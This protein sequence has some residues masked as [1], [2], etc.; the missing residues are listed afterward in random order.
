M[1]QKQFYKTRAWRRCRDA[2]I[3]KRKALD[4]GL[5]EVCR[6]ELGFIVHHKV[7]LNDVNCN[8]PSISLNENNLRYECLTCHNKEKNPLRAPGRVQYGEDGSVTM[9]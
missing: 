4:G 6:D 2:Y 5:C 8:D 9:K 3:S 1:T 7:W